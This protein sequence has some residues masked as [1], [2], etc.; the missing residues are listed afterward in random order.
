MPFVWPDPISF[1]ADIVTFVG[2]PVLSV[3]TYSLYK[4]AKKE[5]ENRTVSMGCMEFNDVDA[6]V[7]VNL[8]PLKQITDVPRIGD[9]VYLP[10]ETHDHKNYGGGLY[11]VLN[12]VF[13]YE[14]APEINQPC[15]ALPVKIIVDVRSITHS[16]GES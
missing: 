2:I 8:V 5:R 1:L 16:S 10:G 11:K 13:C 15:P 12:V 9:E 6:R 14:E 7:G 4:D 3:T